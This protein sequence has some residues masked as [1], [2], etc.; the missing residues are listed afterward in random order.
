MDFETQIAIVKANPDCPNVDQYPTVRIY[1]SIIFM[2]CSYR[3]NKQPSQVL[4]MVYLVTIV[5]IND[6][7]C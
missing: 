5:F 7:L 4:L 2:K 1:L 6:I 3:K